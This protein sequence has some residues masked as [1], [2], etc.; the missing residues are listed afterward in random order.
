[1]NIKNLRAGLYQHYKGGFYQVL[2]LGV[3]TETG[4]KFVVYVSLTPL[5]GPR[6]R[7]RPAA[8]FFDKVLWPSGRKAPRFN[9]I[10][11]ELSKNLLRKKRN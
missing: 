6:I 2:G 7:V 1:M 11:S 3:H 8:I 9:Y 10:G 5:P 4:E